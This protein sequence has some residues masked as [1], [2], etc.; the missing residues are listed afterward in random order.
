MS[1]IDDLLYKRCGDPKNT[2]YSE[3]VITQNEYCGVKRWNDA[4]YLGEGVVVWTTEKHKGN[5]SEHGCKTHDRIFDAAPGATIINASISAIYS[6]EEIEKFEIIYQPSHDSNERIKYEPEEFIKKFKIKIIT[7]SIGGG[8]FSDLKS[9]KMGRFWKEMQD[10]YN[11]IFFNSFGNK[12]NENKDETGDLAIYVQACHLD[13]KGKPVRDYYSSTGISDH[14]FIDFR[15]WDSGTSFSAPYL[16]GKT[17]LL[18]ER[19]GDL[20]QEDVIQYWKDHVEDLDDEGYDKYTGFGLPILGDV[21]EEYD[22]PSKEGNKGEDEM[23]KFKDVPENAWYKEAI[24]YVVE[25]GYMK[26]VSEDEFK[27]DSPLTR[28]QLAQVLYNLEK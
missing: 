22:F 4:G 17:A 14:N 8:M 23:K 15:G 12:G 27:P 2:Y 19:Y 13:N 18:I 9:S 10:K 28:A 7:R 3:Q 24:D 11:L 16:A 20:T 5:S 25:K 6:N 1:K 26:G 21:N